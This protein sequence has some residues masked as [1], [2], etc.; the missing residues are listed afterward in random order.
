VLGVAEPGS[1]PLVGGRNGVANRNGAR[2]AQVGRMLRAAV[3]VSLVCA[4]APAF[5]GGSQDS[6]APPAE[7]AGSQSQPGELDH[8]A[9]GDA[10]DARAFFGPTALTDPEG[11]TELGLRQTAAPLGYLS[12][13]T[14]LTDR[15]ELGVGVGYVVAGELTGVTPSIQAKVQ[16]VRGRYGAIAIMAGAYS[17][18]ESSGM[19][20]GVIGSACLSASSCSVLT[21]AWVSGQAVSRADGMGDTV[22]LAGGGSML[23]GDATVR[24]FVEV[25]SA[26]TQTGDRFTMVAGGVRITGHTVSFDIGLGSLVYPHGDVEAPVVPLAGL[27]ARL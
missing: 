3:A 19:Y 20:V 26:L 23:I 2:L 14:G 18:P 15:L 1:A 24:V 13:S 12:A 8:Y 25:A 7:D 21:T 22:P 27:T 11:S 5:A 16:V 6:V 10:A 9:Y 4:A 17:P